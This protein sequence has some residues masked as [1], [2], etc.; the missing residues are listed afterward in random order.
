LKPRSPKKR[1]KPTRISNLEAQR[2]ALEMVPYLSR[3]VELAIATQETLQAA[4]EAVKR[5]AASK[6][7][8]WSIA[9]LDLITQS[10]GLELVLILARLFDPGAKGRHP[11]QKD[12]ASIPLL[13]RLLTQKRSQEY[14]INRTHPWFSEAQAQ[15]LTF[16]IRC[17][18]A[19]TH[20]GKLY[21]RG[22]KRI[23]VRR[24]LKIL[25]YF[26][27]KRL[28][29]NILGALDNLRPT[30]DQ[31]FALTEFACE[32]LKPA[33]FAVQG[34]DY[35]FE[36]IHEFWKGQAGHLWHRAISD[37]RKPLALSGNGN[38]VASVVRGRRR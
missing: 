18:Q 22:K 6:R 5:L 19:L 12:I 8:F 4:N 31:L 14:F 3:D 34:T 21:G 9:C 25:K 20:V 37:H 33:I 24:A 1:R 38:V 35:R 10:L 15:A 23:E 17:S 13:L 7:S 27:D 36:A 29:H 26:R 2:R 28:A 16:P 32:V 11:N 30:Y